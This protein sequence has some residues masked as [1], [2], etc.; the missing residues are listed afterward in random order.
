MHKIRT[1][2]KLAAHKISTISTTLH[3]YNPEL[4]VSCLQRKPRWQKQKKQQ[5]EMLR[6]LQNG[7][8]VLTT[9]GILGTIVKLFDDALILRVEPD[10]VKLKVA[11]SAVSGKVSETSPAKSS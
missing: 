11:R 6:N 8:V 2:D 9:G 10:N 7:D 3:S 5:A 1:V 4:R